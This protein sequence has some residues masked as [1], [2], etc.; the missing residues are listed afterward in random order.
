MF[1]E[2]AIRVLLR[3]V[4]K[5]AAR[6]GL[7]IKPV[8]S[9]TFD[10]FMKVAV[11]IFKNPQCADSED[12]SKESSIY[13]CH[14][15]KSFTLEPI[16][17]QMPVV[18]SKATD[19]INSKCRHCES[20]YQKIYGPIWSKST[21]DLNFCTALLTTINEHADWGTQAELLAIVTEL[22][23]EL[24]DSPLFYNIDE[25]SSFVKLNPPLSMLQFR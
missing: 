13:Y 1:F 22:K 23:E 9:V 24:V 16:D 11:Q 12:I 25:M 8:F 5:S 20:A 4:H 21:F 7:Y 17:L 10:Q 19:L 18:S 6:Y 15:C 3:A 2:Q 14:M